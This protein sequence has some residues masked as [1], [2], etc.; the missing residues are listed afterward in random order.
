[1]NRMLGLSVF[2]I[3]VLRFSRVSRLSDDR[4]G[5]AALCRQPRRLVSRHQ[6]LIL[7]L[8]A[9]L[10]DN[11]KTLVQH[12]VFEWRQFGLPHT[13]PTTGTRQQLE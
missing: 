12:E 4:D 2:A 13:P 11:N 10:A 3:C 8:S 5:N 9:D 6:R 7:R 1:M